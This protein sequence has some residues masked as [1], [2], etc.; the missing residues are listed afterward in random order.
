MSPC[1]SKGSFC[2]TTARIRDSCLE[3]S[4]VLQSVGYEDVALVDG[5][6]ALCSNILYA[7]DCILANISSSSLEEVLA[8][9]EKLVSSLHNVRMLVQNVQETHHANFIPIDELCQEFSVENG[10]NISDDCS[11]KV[12]TSFESSLGFS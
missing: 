5:I 11:D 4:A 6:T 2:R 7:C 10:F 3:R 1:F 8:G 12:P 9:T